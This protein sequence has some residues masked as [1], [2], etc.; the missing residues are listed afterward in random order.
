VCAEG[1]RRH[2]DRG[3]L[4]RPASVLASLVVIQV[5]LGALNILS[6][7]NPWINSVHVVCG[8]LVLTTS[9]VLTL[10]SWRAAF[11]D[12][13]NVPGR[14]GAGAAVAQPVDV[15]IEPETTLEGGARA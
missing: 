13:V 7:L 1:W 6:Q 14:I 5:T 15:R 2:P 3:E 12:A 10:R 9:L 8:A 11:A 4:T